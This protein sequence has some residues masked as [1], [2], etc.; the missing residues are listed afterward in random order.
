M[1]RLFLMAMAAGVLPAAVNDQGRGGQTA[2]VAAIKQL[3]GKLERDRD[4]PGKPVVG[5]NLNKTKVTDEGLANLEPLTELQE[6]YLND[7]AITDAGLMHLKRL[8][9]L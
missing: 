3:G 2:A 1:A 5:V 9:Q 7:T 4:A 8:K 6:L